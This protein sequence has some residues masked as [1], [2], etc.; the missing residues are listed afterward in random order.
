MLT[1]AGKTNRELIDYY[2]DQPSALPD[3]LREKIDGMWGSAAVQFYALADLD[4]AMKLGHTWVVL[5][6]DQVTLAQT[7]GDGTC[8]EL[9]S[10]ERSRVKATHQRVGLSC[11]VLTLE[12]ADGEAPLAQLRYTHRQRRSMESLKYIL[13]QQA[14]GEEAGLGD[15]D[16]V[17]AAAVSQSIKEA[18]ASVAGNRLAVIW[19]LV[20]YM[21]PYRKQMIFGLTAAVILTAVNLIPPYLTGWLIDR[22]VRRVD[23]GEITSQVAMRWGWIVLA[24]LAGA[25][26]L[27]TFCAWVR[28]RMMALVGEYVARDLRDE[29]Y[30]HL[31]KLS[32]SYFSTKQTGSVISRVSSDTD[33]L[34]DFVA[35]GI[36]DVSLA[37]IMLLG[38]S[39][40]LIYMDWRLGLVMILPLPLLMWWI[41]KHSIGMRRVF[42]RIWRKWSSMMAVLSDTIPG[43]KVVKSFNREDYEKRRFVERNRGVFKE[44]V[45]VHMQWTRFW[46]LLTL[47]FH[48]LAL[49]VWVLALP[50]LVGMEGWTSLSIGTFVSFLLFMGMFMGPVETIGMLTRMLNRATTSAH[51]VFEVLDTEPKVFDV[52]DAVRLD[53]VE[54]RVSFENVSFAYDQVRLII[55]GVDFEVQP[56]EMIGLVGPSGAGKTT[57]INLI[58]RFY[59]STGGRILID[60][61]DITK[62]DAGN[63]RRQIGIVQQ[64]PYL[65]HGT[66]LENIRYGL[67]AATVEQAIEAA[68]AANAHD[69]ICELPHGYETITGERG[70]T[71]SGGERQR[72]SIA[73]ALLC[74]PRILILD[75]A[76]SSVDSETEQKIQ[77]ALDHLIPGRTTFAIAHRLS[78]LRRATRLLV[79]EDGQITEEGT[80]A[81]LLEKDGGKY[82]KMY[83]T[84][85]QL[86]EKYVI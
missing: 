69:F 73:R 67:Q 63:Y 50:R 27:R 29:L 78:T 32:L 60:G 64:D 75:E 10:F 49:L 34:W 26:L 82:R 70:H 55:K 54:G 7:N 84:Q 12:G 74:D 3:W 44:C 86:H 57:V 40:V 65:F 35:F 2:T 58:A 62:L 11:M 1:Q 68:R 41:Y 66:I 33:R 36:V 23:D 19:R 45:E 71:L 25:Y 59:D 47:S 14:K 42:T 79:I 21:K 77:E 48:G 9:R 83:E 31:H 72:V 8:K 6:G 15:A 37:V 52:P 51:R 39:V 81:E 5:S 13:D 22:V 53:P 20:A 38:L 24:V 61:V 76:T 16:E 17:Y 28:L 4:E 56:G 43:M 18:Q 80:H 30:G 46:P 85:Q